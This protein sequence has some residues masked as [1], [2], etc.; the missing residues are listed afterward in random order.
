MQTLDPTR[1]A[2]TSLKEL[3]RKMVDF[4]KVEKTYGCSISLELAQPADEMA[5]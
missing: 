2:D 3:V 1:L 5:S 4:K